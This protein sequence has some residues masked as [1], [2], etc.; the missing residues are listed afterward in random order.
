[1][2]E[3]TEININ[4]PRNIEPAKFSSVF[5]NIGFLFLWIGQLF[6]QL[7]DRIFIYVLMIL[8]YNLT[9][10]NIGVAVPLLSFGIPSLLFGSFAGVFVD[11]LDRK[12]IMIISDLLRGALILLIIPLVETSLTLIFVVSFFIY[13]IAQ[14]FAPAETS[15][16]P[17][18][19]ERKNLIVA[20]SLF[21]IT[22]V[23][24]SM[25]GFG[26]GAPLVGL[27]GEEATFVVAAFLYLISAVAI[28]MIPLKYRKMHKGSPA[29]EFFKDFMT[30]LEF[31]RRNFIINYSLIK[32]F[33]A[34]SAIA[35]IS[36]LAISYAKDILGIGA[37]NFGY[38]II[39]VGLGMLIGLPL[40]GKLS[41]YIKKGTLVIL[42][43][44]LS[45]SILIS[46]AYSSDLKYALVL[47]FFLGICNI[48]VTSSIQTILQQ[49][50]PKGIRGRVFGVQNMLINSAFVIPVVIWGVIADIWGIR[51]ALALLGGIV[52]AVGL[53]S[54]FAPKFKY[55]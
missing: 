12:G 36:L 37:Q 25:V 46:L 1:M 40:L 22:W 55:V 39:S 34:T 48:F 2:T 29:A 52:L 13:T 51:P 32:M 26:L 10:S 50:I 5:T 15:S 3:D 49:K 45:G 9:R 28:F 31:I 43:F 44:L 27:L 17:E 8:A 38:L 23:G 4:I 54:I 21:M 53:A 14:F 18:L 20:N 16:I 6:S 41:H 35:V 30:G 42:G 33:V 11:R 19:V 47:T 7:A 24:S